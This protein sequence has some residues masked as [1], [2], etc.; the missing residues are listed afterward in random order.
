MHELCGVSGSEF[1]HDAEDGVPKISLSSLI[2]PQF[3]QKIV[4]NNEAS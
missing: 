3:T 4:H 1:G 2:P